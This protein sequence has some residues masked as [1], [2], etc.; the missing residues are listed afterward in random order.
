MTKKIHE[1]MFNIMNYQGNEKVKSQRDTTVYTSQWV[2]FK[3]PKTPNIVKDTEHVK[4][5]YIINGIYNSTTTL[6]NF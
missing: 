3:K 4:P 6:E 2:K 1:M 5:P